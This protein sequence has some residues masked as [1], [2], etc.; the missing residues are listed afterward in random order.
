M[1][2]EGAKKYA[3]RNWERGIPRSSQKGALDRHLALYW[4][5]E[6]LDPE[7]GLPH[8]AH[9]AWH[10]LTLLA[11]HLR[12]VGDDDRPTGEA[13]DS[14]QAEVTN[15]EDIDAA[16]AEVEAYKPEAV[17]MAEALAPKKIGPT[18]GEEYNVLRHGVVSREGYAKVGDEWI[19]IPKGAQ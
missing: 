12:G 8:L 1:F 19:K 3:E 18:A 14:M 16:K 13:L 2:G 15:P 17:R 7:S 6:N 10:A 11:L 5:G 9:V 4:A